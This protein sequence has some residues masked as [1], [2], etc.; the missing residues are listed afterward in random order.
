MTYVEMEWGTLVLEQPEGRTSFG[1]WKRNTEDLIGRVMDP[2]EATQ[3]YDA[4]GG[5]HG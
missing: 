5:R 4:L 1:W 2:V 3:S